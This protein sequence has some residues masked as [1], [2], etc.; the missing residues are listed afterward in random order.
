[1]TVKALNDQ[2]GTTGLEFETELVTPSTMDKALISIDTAIGKGLPV[3]LSVGDDT[4]GH[5]VLVT[6]M[7]P[8]PPRRYSIHDPWDGKIV[9]VTEKQMTDGTFDI[10]GW[11]KLKKAF[12]PIVKDPAP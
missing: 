3:P 1:M 12:K 11:N 2:T 5:A 6:G 4:G 10:A 8:G 9:V 7:D